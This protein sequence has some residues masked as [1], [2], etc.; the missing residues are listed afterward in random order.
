LRFCSKMSIFILLC[1]IL[2]TGSQGQRF[3]RGRRQQPQ[4]DGPNRD[5]YN[6]LGIKRSSSQQQIKKAYR[7]L[8]RKY[9]PDKNKDE[10]AEDIYKDVVAAYETLS[11]EEKKKVYDGQGESGV[12]EF[13]KRGGDGGGDPFD[14]FNM[15]GFNNGRR[16]RND[17]GLPKGPDVIIRMK[18]S[19]KTLYIGDIVD[20]DY[21]RSVMCANWDECETDDRECEGPGIRMVT[22]QVGPGF[23]QKMQQQDDRCIA[24]GKR[25]NPNCRAC[26]NGATEVDSIPLTLEIDPGMKHGDQI[27]FED[28]ADE[29]IGH[30]SGDLII[31]LVAEKH[32]FFTRKGEDLHM[33][34]NIPLVDALAGFSHDITHVDGHSVTIAPRNIIHCDSVFRIPGE[35]MP[36]GGRFGDI[37]VRFN[38]D[39]PSHLSDSQKSKLREV[40]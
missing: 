5:F 39:F 7:K 34:I 35:G 32:E 6:I 13:E 8:S 4:D 19:L 9:H 33:R 27:K 37:V 16:R 14:L 36:S 31:E 38:I 29:T 25:Y 24:H 26:P 23:I 11:N 21:V 28:V 17:G 1:F 2:F 40:L 18:V 30:T 10:G 15:F 22:R 3:G 20:F 12:R